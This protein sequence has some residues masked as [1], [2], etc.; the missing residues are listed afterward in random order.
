METQNNNLDKHFRK[1]SEEAQPK[2]FPNM[3]NVWNK[4]EEKLDNKDKKRIIPYWKYA[5]IA[6]SLLLLVGLGSRFIGSDPVNLIQQ[7]EQK[8]V[9]EEEEFKEELNTTPDTEM[10]SI[11]DNKPE[12]EEPV[13]S[14]PSVIESIEI[15]SDEF[16]IEEVEIAV[17]DIET[18]S[19]DVAEESELEVIADTA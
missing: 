17:S 15:A 18:I 5:G 12:K 1:L 7:S 6:A 9:I 13:I 14:V 2:S 11:E 10:V 4:V 16:E 3:E 8:I 19:L